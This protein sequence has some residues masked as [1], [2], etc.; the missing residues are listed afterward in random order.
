MAYNHNKAEYKF[1]KKWKKILKVLKEN[2]LPQDKIN[3]IWNCYREY[4][5]ENR[6]FLEKHVQAKYPI[7]LKN[8]NFP[9]FDTVDEFMYYIKD[10]ALAEL[11]D[12]F[13][14]DTTL[15]V[16]YKSKNKTGKEISEITGIPCYT[17]T[18][19]MHKLKTEYFK[20]YQ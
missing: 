18:R 3:D 6:R 2:D 19:R 12:Q 4:F 1:N 15:I 16:F 11:L 17:I 7:N 14:D 8:T 10:Y 9:D 20:K 5:N 13:D